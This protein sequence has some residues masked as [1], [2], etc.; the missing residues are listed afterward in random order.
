MPEACPG[1]FVHIG[2]YAGI[3]TLG[4]D[5]WRVRRHV[6]PNESEIVCDI[7]CGTYRGGG[8]KSISMVDT[9]AIAEPTAEVTLE[10]RLVMR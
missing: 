6:R 4:G 8:G 5:D 9:F 3:A 7:L 1:E 2:L 10:R